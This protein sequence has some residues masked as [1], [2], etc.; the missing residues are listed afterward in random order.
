MKKNLLKDKEDLQNQ[1]M[2]TQIM[3]L[4]P[5]EEDGPH[6]TEHAICMVIVSSVGEIFLEEI[7]N[8]MSA[9]TYYIEDVQDWI[10]N[11]IVEPPGIYLVEYSIEGSRDYWGEYDAW[12]VFDRIL[13]Y[14]IAI[15]DK[16][17][18]EM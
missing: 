15:T 13:K 4:E 14:N 9:I 7:L 16:R 5:E 10:N 17:Q 3:R 2:H 12:L 1:L 8:P 11:E 18:K 6:G